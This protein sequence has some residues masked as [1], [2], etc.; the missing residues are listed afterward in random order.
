[1]NEEPLFRLGVNCRKHFSIN[2]L[3]A[4]AQYFN[5]LVISNIVSF[6]TQKPDYNF[7]SVI[8]FIIVLDTRNKKLY[9]TAKDCNKCVNA[10]FLPVGKSA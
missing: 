2:F 5:S 7:S 3:V 10:V 8:E 4:E 1:M 9:A 6:V